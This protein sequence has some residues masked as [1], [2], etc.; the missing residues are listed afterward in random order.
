MKEDFVLGSVIVH[1]NR[2][3]A[4]DNEIIKLKIDIFPDFDPFSWE[5]H[6]SEIM[7]GRGVFKPLKPEDRYEILNKT[8]AL[9]G[10][11][12]IYLIGVVLKKSRYRK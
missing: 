8:Y 12:D 10:D 6:A 11:L 1:E 4:V 7:D 2:W 3:K 9:I 5:L